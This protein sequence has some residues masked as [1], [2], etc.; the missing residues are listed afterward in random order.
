M[1]VIPIMT[2]DHDQQRDVQVRLSGD[3]TAIAGMLRILRDAADLENLELS[4]ASRPYPNRREAGYRVYLTLRVPA[5]DD[6]TGR[7]RA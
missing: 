6:A 3:L 2:P 4:E 7:G 5:A 1:E